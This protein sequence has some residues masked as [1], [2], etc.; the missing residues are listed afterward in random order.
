MTPDTNLLVRLIVQDDP[1]QTDKAR[2]VLAGASAVALTL[3][4]L[5]ETCWV[6]KSYYRLSSARIHAAVSALTEAPNVLMDRDAIDTGLAVLAAGGDFA[7]GVIAANGEAMGG[8]I[9]VSFD[10]R[11]VKLL[12]E[13]GKKARLLA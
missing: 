6:L 13:T 3:A 7:D 11:A 12:S 9:F 2:A 4:A 8:D 5:C 10:A 1:V